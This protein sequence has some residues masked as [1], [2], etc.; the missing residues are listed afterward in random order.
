MLPSLLHVGPVYV[1]SYGVLIALGGA[2]SAW[3]WSGRRQRIGIKRDEDF[4]LLINT[5]L[6]GGFLGGRTLFVFEYVKPF[7]P[8]FWQVVFSFSRG[9]SVMGAFAGVLIGVYWFSRRIKSPFLRVLDY[10]CQAA[11]FWHFFG[12]LGCF[13][14]GCCYGKPTAKPWGVVFTDPAAQVDPSLLGVRIHPTQ[15]Y[16]GFGNLI[17]A[18]VLY[19]FVLLPTEKGRLR[20]GTTAGVYFMLY[21]VLRIVEEFYRGDAVPLASGLTA[22]QAFCAALAAGGALLL[23]VVYRGHASRPD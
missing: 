11:P 13:A 7:S 23:V 3:F 5:I 18:A 17:I 16:E 4:W 19:R 8:E 12:R 6:L 21:P 20:P 9:F 14:A 15:L 2:L 22:A 10:V 1:Y